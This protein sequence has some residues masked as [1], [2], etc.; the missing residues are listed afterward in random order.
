MPVHSI[1][2]QDERK[3]ISKIDIR[4]YTFLYLNTKKISFVIS[5]SKTVFTF[6]FLSSVMIKLL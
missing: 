2:N 4:E 5:Y 6:I 1:F 3:K